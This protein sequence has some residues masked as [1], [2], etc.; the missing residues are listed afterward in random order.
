M[1]LWDL[2]VFRHAG[3]YLSQVAARLKTG[4]RVERHI[5][6]RIVK[7]LNR[8]FTGMLVSDDQ[9]LLLATSL[10]P[11]QGRVSR[12]FIDEVSAEQRLGESIEIVMHEG[13]LV[14][15]LQVT[16]SPE[17]R[18]GMPLHLTRYEFLIRVA[19]GALPGSFSREC[20]ED[21]LAFK[22]QVLKAAGKRLADNAGTVP[23]DDLAFFLLQL[24]STGRAVPRRLELRKI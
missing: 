18:C 13:D 3:E 6:A 1:L 16:L 12:L 23:R 19:D 2:T 4:Q 20:Y 14:P 22:S 5:L 15:V 10:A 7:G 8:I 9:R 24:E 21:L 17:N 11:S